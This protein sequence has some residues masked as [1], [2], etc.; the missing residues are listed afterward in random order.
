MAGIDILYL[1]D[2]LEEVL[3]SGS[4]V[5]FMGSRTLIDEQECLDILD[6][7]R[8]ALPEEIKQARRVTAERDSIIAEA[9]TRAQQIIREAEERAAEKVQEHALVRQ[10]QARAEQVEAEAERRSAEIRRE[11]EEYVYETLLNLE[12]D[13]EQLLQTVR[14][15]TRALRGTAEGPRVSS[16]TSHP[17]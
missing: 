15:G 11:A 12:N 14:K 8:V 10:A 13:L 3:N 9:Q 2:R 17:S 4:R 7:I 16:R 5:P 1:L 6:Q